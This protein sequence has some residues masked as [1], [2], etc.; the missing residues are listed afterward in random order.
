MDRGTWIL[1]EPLTVLTSV[2]DP[3]LMTA[4]GTLGGHD[5]A[6]HLAPDAGQGEDF[7]VFLDGGTVFE[8]GLV[9]PAEPWFRLCRELGYEADA[10]WDLDPAWI[11][12]QQVVPA[13]ARDWREHPLPYLEL[14]LPEGVL[15]LAT[16]QTAWEAAVSALGERDPAEA[17]VAACLRALPLRAVVFQDDPSHREDFVGT[18]VDDPLLGVF[19]HLGRSRRHRVTLAKAT[20][21][22][23]GGLRWSPWEPGGEWREEGREWMGTQGP[24]VFLEAAG[25]AGAMVAGFKEAF[26]LALAGLIRV[27]DPAVEAYRHAYPAAIR[28]HR[29]PFTRYLNHMIVAVRMVEGRP[30]L[31]LDDGSEVAVA[32][33]AGPSLLSVRGDATGPTPL[34]S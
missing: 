14:G 5:L 11:L 34:L 22:G 4:S 6:I 1:R 26:A 29:D 2:D 8:L 15:G 10:H 13:L 7:K 20:L 16:V 33:P 31:V 24:E 18:G 25:L 19:V 23:T 21:N 3:Y 32:E 27:L 30:H 17:Q 28:W 9:T 12:F